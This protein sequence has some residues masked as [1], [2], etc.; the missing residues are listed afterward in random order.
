MNPDL[1]VVSIL[2]MAGMFFSIQLKKLTVGGAIAGGIIGYCLFIGAGFTGILLLA[3]F[4]VLGTAATTWKRDIKEKFSGEEKNAGRRTAG[5]VIANGGTAAIFALLA[6]FFSDQQQLFQGMAAAALASAT[7]DT[8]S[9]ELGM[10]YGQKF[11]N[12]ISFK[13]DKR[14]ENGVV[15][16]EGTLFGIAGSIII[17][18]IYSL[19]FG[20]GKDL[21][22]II[23]GGVVGNLIDSVIGATLEQKKYLNNDAVNFFNTIASA[24][25]AWLLFEIF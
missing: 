14:G 6:W 10:V 23:I 22:M 21:I 9:S 15:S 1:L 12:I 17:A 19:G 8:L 11:F 24:L 3:T 13:K 5:Q 16:I 18:I 20:W 7:A 2:L 25:T 4:F